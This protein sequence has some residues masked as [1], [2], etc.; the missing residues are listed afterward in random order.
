MVTD[1]GGL[2]L[3]TAWSDDEG[4]TW[5]GLRVERGTPPWVGG[6]PDITVDRNPGSPSRGAVWVAYNWSG[7]PRRGPGIRVLASRDFGQTWRSLEIAPVPGPAGFR[8]SWRI[9][10]R[11]RTGPD[12]SAY[13][14]FFQADLRTWDPRDVFARGSWGNVGRVGFAIA[15]VTLDPAAGRLIAGPAAMAT[16]LPVNAWTAYNAATPGTAGI[17]VDPTWSLSLDVDP[18]TGRV[19]LAVSSYRVASRATSPRGIVRVGRSDDRGATW[20]WTTLPSLA[21]VAGRQQSSFRPALVAWG[22]TVFVGL[23]GITDVPAGTRPGGTIPTIGTAYVLSTDG[24]RTFGAPRAV[25]STRWSAA[26]VTPATNGMGL[27][28][29]ADRLADGR[30]LYAYADG[31]LAR[32][33]PD[34]RAGRVAVFGALVE[35]GSGGGS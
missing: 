25:S 13:I 19:F 11:V 24:G 22:D 4:R 23:H 16:T 15:R 30:I 31:R 27:R 29:R 1:G 6:F 5:S 10:S 14:A 26:S 2:R 3:A 28:E 21:P 12:G 9:N 34:P 8:D 17:F 35:T 7:D 33:A 20:R 18:A 32:P